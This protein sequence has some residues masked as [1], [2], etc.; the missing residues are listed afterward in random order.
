MISDQFYFKIAVNPSKNIFTRVFSTLVKTMRY[1]RTSTYII[2]AQPCMQ[3]T[4]GFYVSAGDTTMYPLCNMTTTIQSVV[5]DNFV[6]YSYNR[7]LKIEFYKIYYFLSILTY[8]SAF[9]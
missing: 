4:W 6:S 5:V 9:Y 2:S 1:N 3:E 7:G 8:L